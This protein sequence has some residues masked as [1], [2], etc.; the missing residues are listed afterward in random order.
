MSGERGGGEGLGMLVRFIAE[1]FERH[2]LKLF[3]RALQDG[4]ELISELP[5]DVASAAN[6]AYAFVAAVTSRRLLDAD[7]FAALLKHRPRRSGEI[8]TIRQ[9]CLAIEEQAGS[10]GPGVLLRGGRYELEELVGH[11][12]AGS[13]W[14]AIDRQTDAPVAIKVLRRDMRD[15]KLRRW[16]F[17]KGANQM[18]AISHPR[19]ARVIEPHFTEFGHDFCILEYIKGLSLTDLVRSRRLVELPSIVG[20]ILDIG[21]GLA[22]LHPRIFHGDVSP[23]NIILGADG[24]ATLVDFDLAGDADDLPMTR[25]TGH[26]GTDPFAS[27]E[28]RSGG[29]GIDARTDIFSLGMTLVYMLYG[30]ILPSGLNDNRVGGPGPFIERHLRCDPT[31][32]AVLLR[33]CAIDL[34]DRTQTIREFCRDLRQAARPLLRSGPSPVVTESPK[35]APPPERED[36]PAPP[37]PESSHVDHEVPD[38]PEPRT[39]ERATL[40]VVSTQPILTTHEEVAPLMAEVPPSDPAPAASTPRI[41]WIVMLLLIVGLSTAIA[42]VLMYEP[43]VESVIRDSPHYDPTIDTPSTS[44][45]SL[46]AP[47]ATTEVPVVVSPPVEPPDTK[48]THVVE[49][50]PGE[51]LATDSP[52]GDSTTDMPPTPSPPQPKIVRPTKPLQSSDAVRTKLRDRIAAFKRTCIVEDDGS[53]PSTGDTT[54]SL[55]IKITSDG[56]VD[57]Q[58][59]GVDHDTELG[60]CLADK[61]KDEKLGRFEGPTLEY[62]EKVR[63]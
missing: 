47:T 10:I 42:L 3:A 62:T 16:Q 26:A 20:V 61:T 36:R 11:G 12:G 23:K 9:R 45:V 51:P 43:P 24:H 34:N 28:W 19:V 22:A 53:S 6:T 59:G 39:K 38:A 63:F 35:V 17:I 15:Y 57:A 5:G 60:K 21:M 48:Q 13:V 27:P 55:L 44:D 54:I 31:I 18:A 2:E 8:N 49:P 30:E 7:F 29:D 32:K 14:R 40:V 56:N 37:R 46:P 4:P 58:A 33:A 50:P 25:A 41:R 52:H 1:S